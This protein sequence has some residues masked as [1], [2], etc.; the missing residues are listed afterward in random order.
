[1]ASLVFSIIVPINYLTTVAVVIAAAVVLFFILSK[2]SLKFRNYAIVLIFSLLSIG[3]FV[4]YSK[5]TVSTAHKLSGQSYNITATVLQTKTSGKGNKYYVCT[6]N[7][8]SGKDAP[9][10]IKIHLHAQNNDELNDYDEISAVATFFENSES[11]TDKFYRS[12]TVLASAMSFGD[13]KVTNSENFSLLREICKTRDKIIFNI[14]AKMPTEEGDILCGILFGKRDYISDKTTDLFASAGISHLLAVSGLHLSIIV[15]LIN[16]LLSRLFI[17]KVPRSIICIILTAVLS[18]MI[19]FTPS[20]MR[21]AIMLLFLL[22]AQCI[23]EDYDAPTILAFSAVVICLI[24]PFAVTDVG[25]LLSFSATAGLLV[26]QNLLQKLRRKFSLKTVSI[27]K[28][29]A[30]EIAALALPC[31]FAFM[32]TIPICACVFGYVSPYSPIVNL[33]I[34][35]LMPITLAFSLLSAI[36]CLTPIAIIYKP[37]LFIT[38]ILISV[39][40]YFADIFSKLPFAKL[41]LDS[42]LTTPIV[43]IISLMF[44]IALLS[45]SPYKNSVKAALLSVTIVCSAVFAHNSVHLNTT[46]LYLLDSSA[47]VIESGGKRIVSGFTSD[48]GYELNQIIDRSPNKSILYLSSA[49]TKSADISELTHFLLQNDVKTMTISKKYL[50][51]FTSLNTNKFKA[52][53]YL[54][55]EFSLRSGNIA[56]S[57]TQ[58]DGASLDFFNVGSFKIANLNIKSPSNLPAAFECDLLIANSKALPFIEN[59]KCRYFILSERLEDTRHISNYLSGFGYSFLGDCDTQ[60]IIKNKKL[61]QINSFLK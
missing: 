39:I 46:E 50:S 7:T 26:S 2:R 33:I 58:S 38:K 52:K 8:V 23:R 5:V 32:F 20:I 49:S 40:C 14:R 12:N 19:G 22:T 54:A 37:I 10:G 30:Y 24:E 16:A 13:I 9:R 55:D 36:F 21:S 28:L 18:I 45:K 3:I 56:L 25:F 11:S 29:L 1:M 27:P 34:S 17:G 60:I 51:V 15:M 4:I 6:L 53:Y 47:V 57:S 61:Y 35:P 41:Y 31:F 48:S 43:I 44:L 42:E 59:Y